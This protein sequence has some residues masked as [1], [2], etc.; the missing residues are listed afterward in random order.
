[1]LHQNFYS[2]HLKTMYMQTHV[3]SEG[4]LGAGIK[5]NSIYRPGLSPYSAKQ[6]ELIVFSGRF[7]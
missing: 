7:F 2:I 1:M 6:E 4:G 5:P 3:P